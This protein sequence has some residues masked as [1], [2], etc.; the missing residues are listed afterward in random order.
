[1]SDPATPAPVS[2][3][4]EFGGAFARWKAELAL[5]DKDHHAWIERGRKVVNLYK[6]QKAAQ[7]VDR[8]PP[9]FNILWSNVQTLAPAVYSKVP[10]PVAERRWRDRDPSGRAAATILQR[11]LA[12]LLETSGFHR[13]MTLSVLDYLLPGRGTLWL[14]YEADIEA[15]D[16]PSAGPDGQSAPQEERLAAEKICADYVFWEDWRCS[17]SRYWEEV[18]WVARRVFMSRAELRQRFGE[19][20][21][22]VKLDAEPVSVDDATRPHA[23]A[24]KRA[25]VWEIHDKAGR[26]VIWIAPA[27]EGAILD[28][29]GDPLKLKDFFPCPRPLYATLTSESLIPVPDYVLYQD[30]A[31]ELDELT[32]RMT[33]ITK[34]IKVA[35]VYDSSVDA[36]KRLFDEGVENQLIPVSRYEAFAQRGGLEGALDLLPIDDMA[37]TLLTLSQSREQV[38]RDIYE[39]TGISDI[40]RGQG[41]ASETATAQRIKGQF[42]TL[43]LDE[44]QREVQRFALD[45]VR[46]MAELACEHFSPETF[47]LASGWFGTDEAETI[48]QSGADPAQ[49]FSAAL[50][51]LRSDRLRSF[52]IDIETDST[53]AADEQADKESRVE[54]LTAIGGYMQQAL[55]ASQ[56]MPGL[57]PL[58]GKALL[59]AVRGFRAGRELEA[60]FEQAVAALESQG[61]P[62]PPQADPGP[63]A[64]AQANMQAEQ[65]KAAAEIERVQLEMQAARAEHEMR[66]R[67][68]ET[69][70]AIAMAEMQARASMPRGPVAANGFAG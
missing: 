39:I 30:Q 68:M 12:Y 45:A 2:D 6:D 48:A 61:M 54:F 33:A 55:A 70:H 17:P 35:G 38:K 13:A 57:A 28:T 11:S 3:P 49:V 15:Y 56:Q 66:M 32:A 19:R 25:T 67:E 37:K 41:Q 59:F 10:M 26:Q 1:V 24:L 64:A 34:A 43:R 46:I 51:L 27:T 47:A 50:D 40:V 23:E 60:S 9:R 16:A 52:R 4:A 29:R 31:T 8:S 14:A 5:A 21:E 42:A 22:S 69:K 62:Q 65:M 63:D 7:S 44:R 36:L 18:T 58:M 53:I 20:A